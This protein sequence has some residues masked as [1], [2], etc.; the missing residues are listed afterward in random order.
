MSFAKA[1]TYRRKAGAMR[2]AAQCL[3]DASARE[4]VEAAAEAYEAAAQ[5]FTEVGVRR[6]YPETVI[7]DEA[8]RVECTPFPE[9]S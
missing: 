9:A 7:K 4:V 1:M 6:E 5:V 3:T 8:A 2:Q